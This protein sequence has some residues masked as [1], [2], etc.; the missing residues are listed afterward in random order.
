MDI[1]GQKVDHKTKNLHIEENWRENIETIMKR[2]GYS[3]GNWVI[4]SNLVIPMWPVWYNA[5][6]NAKYIIVRRRTG[7]IVNSCIKTGYMNAYSDRNGWIHM[8]RQYIEKMAEMMDQILDHKIVWPHRMAYGDYSQI[9]DILE[10]T[11]TPWKT[12]ILNKIDP[13]FLKIRKNH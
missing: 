11:N 10:W 9:W 12:D 3:D 4:K 5:F 2:Q 6:P 1:L 8:C 7:D 13:K